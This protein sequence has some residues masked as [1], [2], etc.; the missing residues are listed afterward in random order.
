MLPGI[1]EPIIMGESNPIQFE[2]FCT[3]LLSSSEAVTFVPTSATY[4]RGRDARSIAPSRGSHAAI[5]C[6]SLNREI[7]EKV[8]TD[9]TRIS[10]TPTPDRLIY[11][12]SQ[13]LTEDKI[14]QLSSVIKNRLPPSVACS[15]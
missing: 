11:C 15:Y 2:K 1:A 7:D 4:D 6:V 10:S 13:N 3:E 5:L 9:L 8:E 12:S 14:D